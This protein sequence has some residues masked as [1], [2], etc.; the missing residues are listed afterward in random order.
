MRTAL[1]KTSSM[2]NQEETARLQ[3]EAAK[4]CTAK[5]RA[6]VRTTLKEGSKI[7]ALT[8]KTSADSPAGAKSRSMAELPTVP[9]KQV[10]HS[11]QQRLS[12]DGGPQETLPGQRPGACQI[13][14]SGRPRRKR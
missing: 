4:Q 13:I 2:E 10:P 9:P 5:E 14:Q 7:R 12:T 3:L 6:Q 8:A 11:M 1:M